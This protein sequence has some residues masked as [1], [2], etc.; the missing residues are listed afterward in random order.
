MAKYVTIAE[1]ESAMKV[2]EVPVEE[3]GGIV[4]LRLMTVEE[5]DRLSNRPEGAGDGGHASWVADILAR[6]MVDGKGAPMFASPEEG[7]AVLMK[8]SHAAVNELFEAFS[9]MNGVGAKEDDEQGK[10]SKTTDVSV[11]STDSLVISGSPSVG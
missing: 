4:R 10:K 8:C 9:A 11:S 6:V 1:I 5:A 7:V 2:E 3:W